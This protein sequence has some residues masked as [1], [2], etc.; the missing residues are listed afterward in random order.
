M[1]ARFVLL[2][3]AVAVA[4]AC[5]DTP[6]AVDPVK[7]PTAISDGAHPVGG[8][9]NPHFFFLPPM[10]KDPGPTGT[11]DA[12]LSP[13][14]DICQLGADGLTCDP[15]VPLLARFTTD[16]ASTSPPRP[17]NSETVRVS[18]DHYI[19]NWHTPTFALDTEKAYRICVRVATEEEGVFHALGHADVDVVEAGNEKKDVDTE[20][21]VPLVNGRTL[22]IKFR[23][24]EGALGEPA[25]PGCGSIPM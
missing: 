13:I 19:V 16:P 20:T 5:T 11:P 3:P 12:T 9:G 7:S 23:I 8:L 10:V 21:L 1:R 2:A 4:A 18:E 25:D 17:G 15:L 22:P 6:T 24:E 14:V